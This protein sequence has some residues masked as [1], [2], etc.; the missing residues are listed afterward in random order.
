MSYTHLSCEERYHIRELRIEGISY[1]DIARSLGRDK[2]TISRELKRNVSQRGWRP[3]KA[4][5]LAL[6]RQKNSRNAKQVSESDWQSV[7]DYI[8]LDCSPDQAIQRIAL[9]TDRP[10]IMSH[11]TVYKKIYADRDAG[12][13]LI[14]YLRGQKP[15]RKRYA[16]GQERRGV[17]KNRVSIDERPAIVNQKTRIGDWEGDTVIGKDHQGVFV[18]LV[19]RCSRFTAA[20][21]LETRKADLVSLA[22]QRMLGSHPEKCKTITFD[23]GKEFSDHEAIGLALGA[24]IY[25]AHPYHSWERGVN[26]NTNG[27][28]RQY[29]PKKTNLREVTSEQ[30]D[31]MVNKLNNR[32]RKC[33]GY[34]TPHEVFYGLDVQSLKATHVALRT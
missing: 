21:Q 27:L 6:E 12:G 34:R 15:Y 33:L 19:D 2:S 4:H 24:S 1:S 9:E 30:V 10:K 7:A 23:N 32:P 3:Q 11:E 8:R 13:H 29:F 28:I 25:F 16:S 5:S 26:E 20:C 14:K 17:I 31:L 18:T 22:I